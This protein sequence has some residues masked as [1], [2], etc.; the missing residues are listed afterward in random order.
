[1]KKTAALF[2]LAALA[3]ATPAAAQGYLGLEY[4]NHNID[5]GF[6]D[7]DFDVWQ[8]EG[9]FGWGG[10][11]WGAQVGGALGNLSADS[12]GDADF[13]SLDGHLYWQSGAWRLGGVAA[14]TSIDDGGNID[15]TAYGVEGMYSFTNT[16]LSASATIGDLEGSDLWNIDGAVNHY[17]SPNFRVGGLIGFGNIDGGGSD[18]DSMTYGL[19]TEFQPWSAPV[20]I[21]LGWTRFSID[22]ADL[23]TDTLQIGA[24]WN[25]GGGTLQD[26]N[27]R[28]PFDINTGYVNR[29]YGI[30]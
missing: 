27:Q 9:A 10:T 25:F 22:D 3:A 12:G 24:R 21:T 26:R 20:S 16:N 15:E 17:Y 4:G 23:D 6:G 18:V 30:Y 28:T 8:G 1:M 7:E 29:F 5:T 2:A 14:I 11:G 19:N 13:W